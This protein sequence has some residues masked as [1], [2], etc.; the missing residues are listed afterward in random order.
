VIL[1]GEEAGDQAGNAVAFAGDVDGDSRPDL[2]VGAR[3]E[4]TRGNYAGAAYLVLAPEPGETSLAY[5]DAK[6]LGEDAGD[7]AGWSVSGAG[8][9][10]GDGYD[11]VLVGAPG[12]SSLAVANGVTYVLLGPTTG[13]IGLDEADGKISSDENAQVGWSTASVGDVAGD[14][15]GS[16]HAGHRVSQPGPGG[17]QR[18][19]LSLFHPVGQ[20]RRAVLNVVRNALQAAR[21][22]SED[23]SVSIEVAPQGEWATLAVRNRGPVI[24]EKVRGRMFE[25]FYTTREKGTGLGLAFVREIIDDHGGTIEVESSAEEGTVFSMRLPRP[26]PESS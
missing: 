11:D 23:P 19:A 21:G 12:E 18:R 26:R 16:G 6:F 20:L 3:C 15:V 7:G 14:A 8:D 13:A 9:L 1:L 10:D 24:D 5:A 22:A 2:V 25:P 4:S 17:Q